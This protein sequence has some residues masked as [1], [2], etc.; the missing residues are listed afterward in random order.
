MLRFG[1]RDGGGRDV[2]GWWS[3]QDFAQRLLAAIEWGKFHKRGRRQFLRCEFVEK[4]YGLDELSIFLP[5]F[6]PSYFRLL[7]DGFGL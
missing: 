1:N 5:L 3:N 7:V 2:G 6:S 4:G